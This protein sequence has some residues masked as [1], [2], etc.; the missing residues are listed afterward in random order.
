MELLETRNPEREVVGRERPRIRRLMIDFQLKLL[1][2][3]WGSA[4]K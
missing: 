3:I 1:I 4:E 2:G